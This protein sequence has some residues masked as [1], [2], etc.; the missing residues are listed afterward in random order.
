[1]NH[2]LRM[3]YTISSWN[4]HQTVVILIHYPHTCWS[5]YK[6]VAKHLECHV[7]THRLHD[8]YQSTCCIGHTTEMALLKLYCDI[9]KVIDNRCMAALVLPLMSSNKESFK[10]FINMDSFL[11][12]W[13]NL[14]CSSSSKH[15][16]TCHK[17]WFLGQTST[18]YIL[19]QMVPSASNIIC[20]IIA[21]QVIAKFM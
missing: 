16:S 10:S 15:N 13:H 18:V 14:V 1:M 2:S 21:K 12:Q 5:K 8:N 17:D 6:V 4:F 7:N 3:R 19:N 9:T 20:V 11:S